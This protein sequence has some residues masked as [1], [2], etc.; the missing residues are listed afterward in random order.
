ME[1]RHFRALILLVPA[2]ILIG[3]GVFIRMRSTEPGLG[4]SDQSEIALRSLPYL[5]WHPAD[6]SDIEKRGVTL[7]NP[8]NSCDGLNLYNHD[9][10]SECYL[11]DMSGAVLHTWSRP[12]GDWHDVEVLENGDLLVAERDGMLLRLD[13]ASRVEWA[14]DRRYHHDVTV[15]QT[16]DIYALTW[17]VLQIPCGDSTI[18]IVNDYVTILAPDGTVKQ[19]ISMFELFGDWITEEERDMIREHMNN[20]KSAG[21]TVEVKPQ[22]IFDVFHTNTVDI[23]EES[24]EGV[25]RQG[26]LLICIRNLDMVAI[27]GVSGNQAVWRLDRDDLDKPHQ[28]GM[29]GG[30]ILVFDNGAERGYSRVLEIN[31][32]TGETIWEYEGDPRESFFSQTRGGCQRLPNGNTLIA[33]SNEAHVFEVTPKGEIV[34][35]FYGT[36]VKKALRRRRPIYRMTRLAPDYLSLIP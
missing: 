27:I 33:E 36:E 4:P 32:L 31:A 29:V 22:T 17:D 12:E 18:P 8:D 15:A 1:T 16:G 20:A 3:I 25:A 11:M 21:E 5:D 7:H 26:D 28:P 34:W 9:S 14:S 6:R 19:D 24:V 2:I 10:M 35:E 23:L 13:W 30:N